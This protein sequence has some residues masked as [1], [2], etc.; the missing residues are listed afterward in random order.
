MYQHIYCVTLFVDIRT[1]TKKET[2]EIEL[3]L[4]MQKQNKNT[5]EALEGGTMGI[6]IHV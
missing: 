2:E 3:P 5:N 4:I 1:D 6:G